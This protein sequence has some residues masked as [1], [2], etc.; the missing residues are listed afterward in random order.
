MFVQILKYGGAA[1]AGAAATAGVQKIVT[2]K[3]FASKDAGPVPVTVNVNVPNASV[4]TDEK[5]PETK[6][7]EQSKAA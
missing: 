5:K 6:A 2:G 3:W 4:S 1:L 7:K